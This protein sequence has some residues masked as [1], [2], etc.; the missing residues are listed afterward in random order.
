MH[1]SR[2]REKRSIRTDTGSQSNR[3]EITNGEE[4]LFSWCVISRPLLR[5]N[6]PNGRLLNSRR[7]VTS[8]REACLAPLPHIFSLLDDRGIWGK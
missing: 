7:R 5:P 6:L 4:K 3:R 2:H 8:Q 1:A